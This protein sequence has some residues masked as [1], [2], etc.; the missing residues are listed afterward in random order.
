MRLLLCLLLLTPLCQ[1]APL[2]LLL[3]PSPQQMLFSYQ[4]DLGGSPQQLSFSINNNTLNSHFRQFRALKPAL[5]QQY[6]WRDLRAH[7]AQYLHRGLLRL[8]PQRLRV[9]DHAAADAVEQ[10]DLA[11]EA[12]LQLG[13]SK[14]D[15]VVALTRA[16][17]LAGEII[18]RLQRRC[19]D[20]RLA[21]AKCPPLAG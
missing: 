17:K 5:L 11:L 16:R 8:L 14:P 18:E 13:N 21:P 19:A 10:H 3:Q 2:R 1:A 20:P 12:R 9:V 4:F 6:L 15:R 7:V